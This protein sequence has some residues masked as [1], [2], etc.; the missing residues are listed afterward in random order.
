[1]EGNIHYADASGQH[2]MLEAFKYTLTDT[3]FAENFYIFETELEES[4]VVWKVDGH[5]Y[6]KV[7]ISQ[8]DKEE[9][10]KEFFTLLNIV[11]GGKW[12]GRPDEPSHFR[13]LMYID[14][15]RVYQ[16]I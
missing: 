1:M 11:V 8:N 2:H 4:K 7:D 9:V 5:E 13:Q 14:W 12:A 15:V 16:R 10:H 6:A 3:I